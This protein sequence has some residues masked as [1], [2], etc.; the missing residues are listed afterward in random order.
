LAPIRAFERVISPTQAIFYNGLKFPELHNKFVFGSYNDGNLRALK[1]YEN[2]SGQAVK[3]LAL[4]MPM[5][6]PDNIAAVAQSPNGEIYFAGYNIYKLES[7]SNESTL[8]TF[9]I[10]ITTS[11]PT[12]IQGLNVTQEGDNINLSVTG[13]SSNGLKAD[14]YF[15]L[16]IPKNLIGQKSIAAVNGCRDPPKSENL[17]TELVVTCFIK[18]HESSDGVIASIELASKSS[19][20]KTEPSTLTSNPVPKPLPNRITPRLQKSN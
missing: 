16:E 17:T 10:R 20:S 2:K 15:T 6:M 8:S 1:I 13:N 9:P 3:E 5:E 18:T 12:A 11:L 14:E 4:E 19:E 7:I